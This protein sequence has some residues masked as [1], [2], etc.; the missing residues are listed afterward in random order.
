LLNLLVYAYQAQPYQFTGGPAWIRDEHFDITAKADQPEA[1]AT[2][3]TGR[4]ASGARARARLRN[5]LTE[6]FG[7]RLT[8]TRREVSVYAL[9]V[10]KAAPRMKPAEK[11][12]GNM[13]LEQGDGGGTMKAV[14][15]DMVQ[16]CHW[17]GIILDRPVL[18]E[19]ALAGEFDFELKFTLD[20]SAT[21]RTDDAGGVPTLF[22]AIREQLGL[23][24]TGKKGMIASW[25]V[26]RA[27]RP[28]GN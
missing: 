20:N 6:R 4:E 9:S 16:L 28:D 1:E 23:R 27:Q 14:G 15:I 8:E 21:G 18:D 12:A 3:R 13:T 10:E 7:L 26:D 25:I 24:L 22:T 2:D 17:L 5:L 11:P 19:T